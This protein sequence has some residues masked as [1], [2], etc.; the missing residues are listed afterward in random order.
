MEYL[1]YTKYIS[2]KDI[3]TICLVPVSKAIHQPIQFVENDL[4]Y[5]LLS[6][7]LT[8]YLIHRYCPMMTFVP[9]WNDTTNHLDKTYAELYQNLPYVAVESI[10]KTC[11]GVEEFKN[12]I[13]GFLQSLD[14]LEI[15][16]RQEDLYQN[17]RV[18]Y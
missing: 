17:G 11:V 15:K 1:Q 7:E 14:E 10:I 6:S 18:D 12:E 8:S 4:W 13:T 2:K 9:T 3:G 16:C 5:E